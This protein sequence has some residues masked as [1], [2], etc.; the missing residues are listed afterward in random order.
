MKRFGI[1]LIVIAVLLASAS[2]GAAK[3]DKQA[4]KPDSAIAAIVGEEA[5][6]LYDVENRIAFVVATTNLSNTPE[7]IQRLRPQIIRALIDETLELHDATKNELSVSEQEI[8]QAIA[9]IE[10]ERGMK[11]GAIFE[12]MK[13]SRIPKETFT[14]QIRAQLAWRKL[15]MKKIRPLVRVSDDELKLAQAIPTV[16]A[17]ELEIAI[18]TLRVDSPSREMEVRR[19]SEKLSSELRGGASFEEVSRQVS[20]TKAEKFWI[21]PEQL[22]P[23]MARI[24]VTAQANTITVPVR[25]NDGYTIVKV[26]DTRAREEA[27]KDEEVLLKEILLKLKADASAQ[28]ADVLLAIAEDV[29]KHPGTCEEKSIAGIEKAEDIDI[30]VEFRRE[31]LSALPAGVRA[32]TE[33]L[34][35]GEISTPF[36]SD[37]GIRLYMLCERKSAASSVAAAE[38]IRNQLYIQKLDLE[39]QKYLMKLRRETYIEIR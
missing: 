5:I 28:E 21:R 35:T 3:P 12:L 1:S 27:G 10:Q 20:G 34:K 19:L 11:P 13:A 39:V 33:S 18:L 29:A 23:A 22:D 9:A 17:Q 30:E 38:R 24:L 4:A 31:L 14:N 36:A 32:I 2:A 6:S 16:A 26:Y 8:A 7:V 15:V 25:T 37:S